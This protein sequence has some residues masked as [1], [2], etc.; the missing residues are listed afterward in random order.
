MSKINF[1]FFITVNLLLFTF[2]LA[3]GQFVNNLRLGG[4]IGFSLYLGSQMDY[5]I[6]LNTYGKSEL[7]S[8]LH[9]QI[10][11]T[12]NDRHEIGIRALTTELWSFKS[13]NYLGLNAK[14][15]DVFLVHQMSLN[16]NTRIDNQ[17][18]TFNTVFGIGVIYYRSMF[19]TAN[20]ATQQIKQFSSV[21][22]GVTE[23]SSGLIIPEQRPT[24]AGMVGFNIGYRLNR[25]MTAYLENSITLS[26]SNKITGNL[27]LKS[28]LPNNGYSFHSLGLYFNLDVRK[29]SLKC[30]RFY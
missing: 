1:K 14:I 17:K 26:G 29:S 21:G 6:A 2:K 25:F 3:S 12:I 7:N 5:T 24:I 23:V 18:F 22:N 19:Y 15:N 8:G 30:P 13:E 10:F 11:Y 16:K 9:G 28:N 27:L 4:G 20:P